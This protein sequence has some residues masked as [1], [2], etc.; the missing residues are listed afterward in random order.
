MLVSHLLLPKTWP[1]P[2]FLTFLVA[3]FAT[4]AIASAALFLTDE[5]PFSLRHQFTPARS[6]RRR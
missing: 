2:V 4:T 3:S 1:V 5:K 6:A